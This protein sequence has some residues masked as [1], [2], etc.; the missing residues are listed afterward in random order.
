LHSTTKIIWFRYAFFLTLYKLAQSRLKEPRETFLEANL[1]QYFFNYKHF[2]LTEYT[3]CSYINVNSLSNRDISDWS[4]KNNQCPSVVAARFF[5]ASGYIPK[6]TGNFIFL[7]SVGD[8]VKDVVD[9]VRN[10]SFWSSRMEN[11]FIICGQVD[12]KKFLPN[13][14][15]VIWER[16]ILNFVVV[17]V[18]DRLEVFSYNPFLQDGVTNLSFPGSTRTLFPDKLRNLHGYQLRVSLFVDF[19]LTVKYKGQWL[20]RD[21]DRLKMVAEMINATFKIIEA[22]NDTGYFGAYDD[23]MENKSDFCFITHFYMPNIFQDVEYTYPHQLNAIVAVVPTRNNT[24]RNNFA[25]FSSFSSTTWILYLVTLVLFSASRKLSNTR[26]S[27][28]V[29]FINSFDTF[30]GGSVADFYSKPCVVKLKLMTFILGSI[31]FRTWFQCALISSFI[32]PDCPQQIDTI[33]ALRE[34]KMT[35]CTSL[36]LAK[37][38]PTEYGL[39]KQL[40]VVTPME[41]QRLLYNLDT[42]QAYVITIGFANKYIS[43]LP[44]TKENLAFGLLEEIIVPGIGTY[45]FQKHSPF[46]DKFSELLQRATLYALSENKH[47]INPQRE[48]TEEKNLHEKT[49]SV[50]DHNNVVLTVKHLQS[51]FFLWIGGL[52]VALVS[53]VS[54]LIYNHYKN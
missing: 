21:Y 48:N 7:E 53:F 22:Q 39:S 34:S 12:D 13:L 44:R 42:S 14:L 6:T 29:L 26:E 49:T 2:V 35:I 38:I 16:S 19:P 31:I 27:F 41:R 30:L 32:K 10:Y 20:G 11:H 3:S 4:I 51:V 46:L 36:S 9:Q 15:R 40:V 24:G 8:E 52:F 43:T 25:M 17:F 33:E 23:I 5:N 1:H 47:Q 37:I 45:Y 50:E 54:E 28:V 18:F